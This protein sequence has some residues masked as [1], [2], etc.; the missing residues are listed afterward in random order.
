M[1]KRRLSKT[2]EVIDEEVEQHKV[3]PEEDASL[4]HDQQALANET[5]PCGSCYGAA[6]SSEQCC[7]TCEEVSV[8]HTLQPAS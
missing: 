4:M 1:F 6:T 7:N 3:G 2:G 8:H 5:K